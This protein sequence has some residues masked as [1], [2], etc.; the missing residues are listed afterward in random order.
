MHAMSFLKCALFYQNDSLNPLFPAPN[1][2]RQMKWKAF[3]LQ[4]SF[5]ELFT[6][7]KIWTQLHNGNAHS[8]EYWNLTVIG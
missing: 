3:F 7:F 1:F 4:K 5:H 8:T 6:D 2:Q